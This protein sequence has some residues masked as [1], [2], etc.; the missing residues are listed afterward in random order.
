MVRVLVWRGLWALVLVAGAGSSTG[1]LLGHTIVLHDP[2]TGTSVSAYDG[3]ANL[4]GT[5]DGRG[6]V[7]AYTHGATAADLLRR[8]NASYD[9]GTIAGYNAEQRRGPNYCPEHR[10]GIGDGHRE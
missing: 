8:K 5:A 3:G 1:D 4:L 2:D 10:P 7:L 6:R 9:C